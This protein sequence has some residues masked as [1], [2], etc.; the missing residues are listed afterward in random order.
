[1]KKYLLTIG[2]F[3]CGSLG[4]A[5]EHSVVLETTSGEK[6]TYYFSEFPKI[7]HQNEKVFL[8]TT[9]AEVQYQAKEIAKVYVV[10]ITDPTG[11]LET[12]GNL[13]TVKLT[14]ESVLLNGFAPSEDVLVYTLNG[15]LVES[16][17]VMMDGR[18][19]ISLANLSKGVYLIKTN[20]QSFK[21][22]RK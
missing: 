18:L 2:L 19:I 7:Q 5:Q 16:Y 14:D 22:I 12:T 1:M 6:Y 3:L 20:H 10:Q 9:K 17:K 21:I 11:I 4:Y 13:G 15:S 8:C